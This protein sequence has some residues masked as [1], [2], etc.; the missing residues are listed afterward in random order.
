MIAS[1]FLD[2]PL[3]VHYTQKTILTERKM[4]GLNKYLFKE[5][6]QSDTLNVIE[7]TYYTVSE[8]YLCKH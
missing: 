8:E 2:T 1:K 4:S 7:P 6:A 5:K 3:F